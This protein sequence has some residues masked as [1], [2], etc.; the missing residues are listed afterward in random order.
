MQLSKAGVS[1]GFVCHAGNR[2]AHPDFWRLHLVRSASGLI[3][4][5]LALVALVGAVIITGGC[6]K[7]NSADPGMS[8]PVSAPVTPPPSAAPS[9]PVKYQFSELTLETKPKR[10]T[11]SNG[12]VFYKFSYA[13]QDGKVY[14]CNLPEAMAQGQFTADGWIRTFKLYREPEA[15][16][17]KP[18]RKDSNQDS[19]N[20]FPFIAPNRAPTSPQAVPDG[21]NAPAPAPQASPS[22]PVYQ[23]MPM[24]RG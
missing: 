23:P 2:S 5:S 19:L 7:S 12:L 21:S 17:Q 8:Q 13:D 20:D 15:V 1:S 6:G 16:D 9:E 14:K 24:P 10:V 18:I 3:R 4:C 11:D 22:E